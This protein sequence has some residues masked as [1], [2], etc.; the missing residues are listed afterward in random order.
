[1][2]EEIHPLPASPPLTQLL[3]GY[4]AG[5]EQALVTVELL[6]GNHSI[7]CHGISDKSELLL[8]LQHEIFHY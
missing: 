4:E 8:D 5:P 7:L 2:P 1:M 6:I 3:I